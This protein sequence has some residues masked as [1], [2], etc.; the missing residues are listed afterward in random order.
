MVLRLACAP[1]MPQHTQQHP[2]PP[3]GPTQEELQA[4][5]PAVAAILVVPEPEVAANEKV[6][7]PGRQAPPPPGRQ[8]SGTAAV[9]A[10]GYQADS[11]PA[12]RV[13]R[14]AGPQPLPPLRLPQPA[15]A[16]LL[17]Q[18]ACAPL[19][20]NLEPALQQL[21]PPTAPLAIPHSPTAAHGAATRGGGDGGGGGGGRNSSRQDRQ[22]CLPPLPPPPPLLPVFAHPA[23]R[24]PTPQQAALLRACSD[25]DAGLASAARP[26]TTP[27]VLV[28]YQEDWLEVAPTAVSM[29]EKAPLEPYSAPKAVL[30]YMIAAE[31]Q[32]REAEQLLREVSDVYA[33]CRLG[34]HTPAPDAVI[35]FSPAEAAS[36]GDEAAEL[37]GDAAALAQQLPPADRRVL[38]GM[39]VTARRLQQRLLAD[40]P[41]LRAPSVGLQ[42][43]QD[44][45][46][47]VYALCPSS[48]PVAPAVTQL[49]L[50]GCLAPCLP[51]AAASVAAGTADAAEQ[52]DGNGSG[53]RKQETGPP[54]PVSPPVFDVGVCAASAASTPASTAGSPR[55]ADR[56]AVS[57]SAA[58]PVANAGQQSG[59]S[60]SAMAAS[61]R[62]QAA[63]VAYTAPA[64]V[65][66]AADG[67]T[68]AAAEPSAELVARYHGAALQT[69]T[70]HHAMPAP[71]SGGGS[72]QPTVAGQPLDV[73]LQMVSQ[74]AMADVTGAA[75]RALAFSLFSKLTRRQSLVQPSRGSAASRSTGGGGTADVQEVLHE[76]AFV[77]A[78]P[79]PPALT[80][81]S[82]QPPAQSQ[83]G[84]A[85]AVADGT[86]S[87]RTLHCCYACFLGDGSP[88]VLVATDECGELLHSQL[89]TD[90]AGAPGQLS[91]EPC[92]RDISS[93][94]SA[95]GFRR[96]LSAALDIWHS[97]CSGSGVAMD[98]IVIARLGAMPAAEQQ[99][100]RSVLHG[101]E[102]PSLPNAA[103]VQLNDVAVV[104]VHADPPIRLQQPWDDLRSG[105]Y[106]F[107]PGVPAPPAEAAASGGADDGGHS[108]RVA[109]PVVMVVWGPPQPPAAPLLPGEMDTVRLLHVSLHAARSFA[110]QTDAASGSALPLAAAGASGSGNAAGATAANAAMYQQVAEQLYG[111][112][113]LSAAHQRLAIAA[114]LAAGGTGLGWWGWA[115]ADAHLPLHAA[116]AQ[117]AAALLAAADR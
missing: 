3:K 23:S 48:H 61:R 32:R 10:A 71:E 42:E 9:T 20:L 24:A 79:Q 113:V 52:K 43:H 35:T 15:A 53:G 93:M 54:A 80:T 11:R 7:T 108:S 40:P 91:T 38:Q 72:C 114:P 47:A 12:K 26:L 29:W 55:A 116:A 5:P 99:A 34:S 111:L 101:C 83:A 17:L 104:A 85:G 77:L 13:R 45:S 51:E 90:S 33:A 8:A 69:H 37:F 22:S 60:L 39:C 115:A 68:A 14:C 117:R 103:S 102:L 44:A 27:A 73:T 74:R 109:A 106:A 67:D 46:V 87:R 84:G 76:P 58:A 98:R 97:V 88:A 89:L 30:Y 86:A 16:R 57:A 92:S 65:Q 112:A 18:A 2:P 78:P 41:P 31:A 107:S 110:A 96:V 82:A 21:M 94:S 81:S 36:L 50:A 6:S 49:A 25:A 100:W 56:L 28:G 75:V 95:A 70:P 64:P 4:L 59:S 66:Q 1:Y 19:D 105:A 63:T 62:T